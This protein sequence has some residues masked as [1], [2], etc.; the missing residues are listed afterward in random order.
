MSATLPK[1]PGAAVAL[2]ATEAAGGAGTGTEE[3][4]RLSASGPISRSAINVS[5]RQARGLVEPTMAIT[6]R[7]PL[8]PFWQP[9]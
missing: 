7:R 6:V 8:R 4:S 1:L 2:G 5:R 3:G 9:F